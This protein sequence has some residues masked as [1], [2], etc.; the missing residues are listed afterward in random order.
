MCTEART[1]VFLPLIIFCAVT[2]FGQTPPPYV[3]DLSISKTGPDTAVADTDVT[4]IVTVTNGGPDEAASVQLRDTMPSGMS[5]VS[6]TP[7]A[8]CSGPTVNVITCNFGP[9]A[10]GASVNYTFVFHIPPSAAPGTYYTNVATVATVPVDADPT[11]EN[12][13]ASQTTALPPPPQSDAGIFKDGP[14]AAGPNTDVSYTITVSNAGSDASPLTWTDTLPSGMTFVSLTQNSGPTMSCSTGTTVSCSLS[15]FPGGATATFTLV[16]HIPSNMTSGTL[17][18]T[19]TVSAPN[20]PN[21]ENDTSTTTLNISSVDMSIVK[22]GPATATAGTSISYTIT[23]TNSGPDSA[24][25]VVWSDTLPPNTT[26]SSVSPSA[27]CTAPPVGLNGTVS[28]TIGLLAPSTPTQYTLTIVAGNTPSVTNTATVYTSSYDTNPP[29]NSS[30]ATTTITPVSDLA[31]TKS[32]PAAATPGTDYSYT[33][34]VVNNG[35]TDASNVA[36]TDVFPA[37][38]TFVS[39]VQNSG[40][41]FTCGPPTTGIT[42]TAATFAL[43]ATATFTLTLHLNA[44][45]PNGTTVSN[46]ATVSSSSADPNLNNN[47]SS[48][49]LTAAP[50]ADLAV[51]KSGPA[52]VVRGTNITYNVTITNNGPSNAVNVILTDT[53][54]PLTTFVSATQTGGPPFT[55]TNTTTTITCTAAS[56]A[57]GATASFDFV[58]H[59][60]SDARGT[61]TNTVNAT[62]STIDPSPGNA[63]AVAAAAVA[64]AP[65]APALSPFALAMLGI[66][67]AFAGWFVARQS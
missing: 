41:A 57:A 26:F 55:C 65:D 27:G 37:N 58:L 60:S 35:P 38:T 33:I 28:C 48:T 63:T 44:S 62:S 1:L 45:V 51:T 3:A 11:D 9:L 67:L 61:I 24:T 16:G 66:A 59:V 15:P 50:T 39:M 8:G 34:S 29:N 64:G 5:F 13:T 4:Y 40:P 31:I 54:P 17:Q 10:S 46:T 23:I 20:D 56:L 14:G 32:G 53:M 36:I 18:N 47:S 2:A 25:D 22:T 19:A 52:S 6:V 12:N 49:N 21:P 30:N 7:S 43:G 42:C